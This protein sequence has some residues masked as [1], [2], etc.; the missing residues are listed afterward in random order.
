MKNAPHNQASETA[1]EA[2]SV[3][4]DGPGGIAYT[5]TPG[6]ARETGERMKGSATEAERQSE[7]AEVDPLP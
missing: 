4:V 7:S 1:A 3:V 5:M 6:A 2:G